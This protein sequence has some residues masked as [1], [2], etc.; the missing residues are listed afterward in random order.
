MVDF[1]GKFGLSRDSLRASGHEFVVHLEENRII[2]WTWLSDAFVSELGV[3][4][5]LVFNVIDGV[6][7]I[8]KRI[9]I[10]DLVRE[11]V[12][13]EFVGSPIC[14]HDENENLVFYFH[15]DSE[16]T[17]IAGAP[18]ILKRAFPVPKQVLRAQFKESLGTISSPSEYKQGLLDTFD[19]FMG[20]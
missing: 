16:I 10:T 15:P 8:P 7:Q 4:E 20:A 3:S 13:D 19:H 5:V 6:G 12:S 2:E 14:I 1:D 9:A 18:A 17:I 11:V